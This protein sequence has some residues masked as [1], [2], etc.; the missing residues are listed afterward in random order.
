MT[1]RGEGRPK[2]SLVP[3]YAFLGFLVALFAFN[4]YIRFPIGDPVRIRDVGPDGIV[5]AHGIWY[6]LDE[7]CYEVE[8]HVR[9]T[10]ARD[11]FNRFRH[12][13]QDSYLVSV[14]PASGE[15]FRMAVRARGDEAGALAA[16]R[17]PELYGMVSDG[18]EDG[19]TYQLND[20]GDA[21]LSR[22]AGGCFSLVL[23]GAS[24]GC[25]VLVKKRDGKGGTR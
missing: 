1:G 15:P 6:I 5:E 21:I 22:T 2:G 4:A 12:I 19:A 14:Q 16:G 7:G 13:R 25:I 17:S 20:N 8:G 3:V 9:T 23:V 24:I 18:R 10:Y 11:S